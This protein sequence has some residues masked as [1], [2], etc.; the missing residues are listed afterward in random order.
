M[1]DRDD[2]APGLGTCCICEGPGANTIVMLDRRGAEPGKG[3][4][5]VVCGLPADGAYAVLCDPCAERYAAGEAELDTACLGYPG[6]GR[7]IPI[8]DL[9]P[10]EFEHD[11]S[12]HSPED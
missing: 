8:A 1:C 2:D 7:R 12:K 3:W 9:P 11:F 6:E 10:G 5:C 4:G